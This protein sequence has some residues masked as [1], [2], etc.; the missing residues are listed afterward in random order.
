MPS[1][2]RPK[3]PPQPYPPSH[4]GLFAPSN[5]AQEQ[6]AVQG[7]VSEQHTFYLSLVKIHNEAL[8]EKAKARG[9]LSDLDRR[10]KQATL[11]DDDVDDEG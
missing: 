3:E 9:A 1:S 5:S 6:E 8:A 2:S 11:D 10:R 4:I 7:W